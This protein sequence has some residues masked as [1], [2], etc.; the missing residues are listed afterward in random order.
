MLNAENNTS[1]TTPRM[2]TTD[3][4]ITPMMRQFLDIKSDHQDFLLFYRMGDFYE[5]F[6]DDAIIAAAALDITL[7]HRG[8]H[9][10]ENIP[11]CGVPFHAAES[12]LHRLIRQGHKV[13][14]CE[15][16]EDPAEAK[17]RGSKSVVR[18]EVVRLVTAG[19]LTEEG[20]LEAG[21]NNYLAAFGQTRQEESPALA[22]V[23][24]STGDVQIFAGTFEAIQGRLAGLMPREL[25]LPD[26]LPPEKQGLLAESCGDVAVTEL[27]TSQSNSES[28]HAALVAAYQ[29]TTLEGFGDW[30]RSMYAAGGSLINYLTL[31]QL[32]KLPNLKPPRLMLADDRMRIDAAT[33]QNLEILQNKTGEKKGSLFAAI[34]KTVTGPGARML[35]QR[36]AAP[37]AQ[38]DAIEGRLDAIS[39]Y[40]GQG[41]ETSK[42]REAKRLILKQTPDMARAL[43]RLSLERCGPRDLAA[44]RD[45][46]MQGFELAATALPDIMP[47]PPLI[48]TALAAIA[49][50][51]KP[52]KDLCNHLE[53][54]LADELPILT[55]DGGFIATGYHPGLDE[56]R[57]LRDESRRVVAGLQNSYR[58]VTGIKALKVKHNAVLGYHIDVPAAHGDRLM[59]APFVETF[60]HRQTLANSVRFSTAELAELAGQISRAGEK[61][62]GLEQEIFNALCGEV[63]AEADAIS[64]A[65]EALAELDVAL[66]LAELACDMNWVRPEIHDDHRFFV[67]GGR[68]PVVEASL[69]GQGD[70]PFIANDCHIHADDKQGDTGRLLLLTGPNMAG[71]S[72]YLRQNALIAVLAQSGCY[73]PAAKAEI[74][75]VDRLF[76]RVGAADDLARGQSTFM[77]EMVETSAILNQA[78]PASLVILDEIGRGTSTFDGLSIAWATVEHMHEINKCRTMFATHYHEL[79]GLSERLGKVTNITM[80]VAEYQGDVVFLHEVVAGAADRSYGIHVA[81]L[82]GLPASVIDRARILLEKLEQSREQAVPDG[83]L[84]GLP[85]FAPTVSA[86]QARDSKIDSPADKLSREVAEIDPDRLSPKEALDFIYHLRHIL[87]EV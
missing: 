35:S 31:T 79:T 1:S 3:Q 57:R 24:M 40:A 83:L 37:L 44:V 12:Y 81:K 86:E 72:T 68:H 80:R 20:L 28:G 85:L 64:R 13:A 84:E 78:G 39:F 60:F 58:E 61:A 11:M 15:Q 63:L 74:G 42:T 45:G 46:L 32:G 17:K 36:L 66:A 67:E 82:A 19:T 33:C 29:V 41:A 52:L 2:P 47:C 16:T 56:A 43:G 65:A 69:S 53:K 75:I 14:I 7:T 51:Q 23:D 49:P 34:D 62:T 18:R 77:V 71:K 5:L 54:V 30:S 22:W 48:E 76:S 27:T 9:L 87:D 38:K 26:S 10:D 50:S 6:F 55:R 70:S 21:V 8:K 25:L 73:V 59:T 4:N